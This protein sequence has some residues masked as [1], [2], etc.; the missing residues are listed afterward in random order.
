MINKHKD[1]KKI[2]Y[3]YDRTAL[4]VLS[5]KYN[6]P[7]FRIDQLLE[8]QEKNIVSVDEM[9]NISKQ[10]R[11]QLQ[12]EMIWPPLEI[13][14]IETSKKEPV[15]KYLFKLQD[16]NLIETVSMHYSY[17]HSVCLSTQVGC[18]MG[19]HFCASAKLGLNRNLTAGE[20]L[21]QIALIAHEEKSRISHVVL[22]GIGEALDNYEESI[23]FLN[24]LRSKDGIT[25]SLRNVT[26][27][28]C[29]LVPQIKKLAHE[30]LPI[31]L[32]ISLHSANQ[33]VRNT[34]M[35][36]AKHYPIKDIIS[37]AD[38]YFEKTGRRVTYEYTLFK[39]I[40]DMPEEAEKLANLLKHKNVHV[41]LIPANEIP[42][43]DWTK[44]DMK[45]IN[46]FQEILLK[47]H[48][49]STIRH[50]AGQDITAACGQ[51]RRQNA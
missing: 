1:L 28:T 50:S 8:W 44:L 24:R 29:G 12:K 3:D 14:Q 48:I 27:S 4:T 45:N 41:N 42:D 22:M 31:T 33:E 21:A 26:L 19:C 49:N 15:K 10:I 25:I 17:G 47:H 30:S 5:Q 51:L 18:R 39:D 34:L 37:A 6:W 35:P 23:L 38:Y 36:I 46:Q 43:S 32:A 16:G 20:M 2:F 13:V 11:E 40:N 7:R 9:T